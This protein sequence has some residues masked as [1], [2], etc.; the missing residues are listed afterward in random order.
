MGLSV[1]TDIER[2]AGV[3]RGDR[4]SGIDFGEMNWEEMEGERERYL[5]VEGLKE[6]GEDAERGRQR[7]PAS[8]GKGS[9]PLTFP[10]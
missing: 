8:E 5:I 9:I 6:G 10:S 2:R 4:S 3:S 7:E 1:I